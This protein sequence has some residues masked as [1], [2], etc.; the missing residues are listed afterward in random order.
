MDAN[1]PQVS[2]IEGHI[3]KLD[4]YGQL[5]VV[6]K[7]WLWGAVEEPGIIKQ[8]NSAGQCIR[9]FKSHLGKISCLFIWRDCIYT[10]FGEEDNTIQVWDIIT[11]QCVRQLIGDTK[12]VHI[13]HAGSVC[14]LTEWR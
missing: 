13:G 10:S 8:W 11:G 14:V 4:G 3:R 1:S 12:G 7:D 6:Y 9:T 2:Q 5:L